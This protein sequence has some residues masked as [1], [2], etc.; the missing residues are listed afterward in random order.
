MQGGSSHCK[1]GRGRNRVRSSDSSVRTCIQ[2][3]VR[4][5]AA[6]F[7]PTAGTL[8]SALHAMTQAWQPVQR[9]RSITI[10]QSAMSGSGDLDARRVEETEAS[11]GVRL[12][13]DQ[14]VLV[15]AGAAEERN[16]DDV[17]QGAGKELCPESDPAFRGLHPDPVVV[18]DPELR[19]RVRVNLAPSLP[20]S[21]DVDGRL[22]EEPRLI[23]PAAER[24]RD[25]AGRVETKRERAPPGASGHRG[26]GQGE[27]G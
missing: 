9:S 14:I 26:G 15:R 13:A 27:V 1:H 4:P 16:V 22:L 21:P 5:R 2:L 12:V 23:P 20:G 7:A 3:M 11:E 25:Q 8:F 6:S 19:G 17:G 18:L 24:P 10:P